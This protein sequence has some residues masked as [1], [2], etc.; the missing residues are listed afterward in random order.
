VE[1][2]TEELRRECGKLVLLLSTQGGEK[3]ADGGK[4]SL[5][6]EEVEDYIYHSREENIYTLFDR[7]ARRDLA[8][9]LEVCRKLRLASSEHQPI[10]ILGSMV[11]QFRRLLDLLSALQEGISFD[12]ACRQAGIFGKRQAD[13]YRAAAN[14]YSLREA[15][16][17]LVLAAR[18]DRD[19]RQS[20]SEIHT[21]L[22][23]RFFCLALGAD[24]SRGGP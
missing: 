23:D 19:L 18:T 15:E 20:G 7:A 8:A 1:N 14:R 10:Q 9:A 11:W 22:L 2:N 3:S 12:E 24:K 21:A 16:T 5:S 6:S 17:I 4:P 13:C